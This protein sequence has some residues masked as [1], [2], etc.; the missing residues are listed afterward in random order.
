[1][2]QKS[3][4]INPYYIPR[5]EKGATLSYGNQSIFLKP[6]D[7]YKDF[8]GREYRVSVDGSLRRVKDGNKH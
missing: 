6:G 8:S 7:T 3:P 2:L 4:K 1:M 5:R